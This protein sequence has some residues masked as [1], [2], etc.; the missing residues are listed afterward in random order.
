MKLA[1]ILLQLCCYKQRNYFAS[2]LF[3]IRKDIKLFFFKSLGCFRK[4]V[5]EGFSPM[6]H[7]TLKLAVL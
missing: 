1:S 5:L 7:I 2:K 4:K 3:F 6:W